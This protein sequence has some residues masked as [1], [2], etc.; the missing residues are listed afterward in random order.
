MSNLTN[1]AMLS[2]VNRPAELNGTANADK[3]N[4]SIASN[5]VVNRKDNIETVA[6]S[7]TTV[8][9]DSTKVEQSP[10]AVEQALDVINRAMVIEQRSLSF[11]VDEV[12]GRSIIKVVDQQTDQLIRQIPTD[13][14]LRVAQD[15]KKLQEEMGQS[16]GLLID[17][18]V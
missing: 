10:Q 17:R 8:S 4:N 7:K 9:T 1:S 5:S 18:K 3:V 13:E 12:S 11:S 6:A 16:L 14:V 15:I 2:Y